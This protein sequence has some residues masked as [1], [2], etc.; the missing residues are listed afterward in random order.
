MPDKSR[1]GFRKFLA[2]LLVLLAVVIVAV[3]SWLDLGA[4]PDARIV[5]FERWKR[6]STYAAG[7]TLPG[8]PDLANLQERL[9]SH[10][11]VLGVPVLVRI[12]KREFDLEVWLL[13]DGAFHHF[14][15]YPIC[16]WS[17]ELGPKVRQGDHQSP[18][19]F[20]TVDQ[21]ALNPNS[22]WHRSFNLGYPNAFD[23]AFARTGS[24]IMVHGGCSSVGC[25]AM[26]NPVIDEIWQLVTTA[27]SGG[28]K[29][30][31]VQVYPFRM[32]DANLAARKASPQHPFWLD[33]K[34]G[35]DLFESTNLPP[36][37]NVCNRRY[38]FEPAAGPAIDGSTPI[39]ARCVPGST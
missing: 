8:T 34:R 1:R 9:K 2:L 31:Q 11:S 38:T 18:E 32:T 20:Y 27:L 21:E 15:T 5:S 28:Q 37:V 24:L 14:A 17:G 36:R 39:A 13:R 19:G 6:I 16:R 3:R 4:D 12:F 29:R 22:N 25:F 35:H 23:R 7:Y 33:L 10:G 30:F 26:T